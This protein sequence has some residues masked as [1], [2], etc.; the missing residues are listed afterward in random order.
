MKQWSHVCLVVLAACGDGGAS[1]LEPE[2]GETQLGVPAFASS[3]LGADSL[4]DSI[5]VALRQAS[6]GEPLS[7]VWLRFSS[8]TGRIAPKSGQ[9]GNLGQVR[10]EWR[11]PRPAAGVN[12]GLDVCLATAT[13]N[14]C[15]SEKTTIVSHTGQ[16]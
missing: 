9:T 13:G 16:P 7:G 8:T 3:A 14:A 5:T 6:S 1:G 2:I 4:L 15:R 12:V 10:I 11:L